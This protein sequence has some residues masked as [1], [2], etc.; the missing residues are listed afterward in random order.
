MLKKDFFS[1]KKYFRLSESLLY[2]N[3]AA[4]ITPV[5][6]DCRAFRSFNLSKRISM[7]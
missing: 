7:Q 2:E 5:V 4:Q 3:E 1:R 6:A